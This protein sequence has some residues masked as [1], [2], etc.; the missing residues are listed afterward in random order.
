MYVHTSHACVL[1]WIFLAGTHVG[2]TI[3]C[4]LM[5]KKIIIIIRPHF[6]FR[7]QWNFGNNLNL[8]CSRCMKYCLGWLC[9]IWGICN[10][11]LVQQNWNILLRNIND[12]ILPY[13]LQFCEYIGNGCADTSFGL[14]CHCFAREDVSSSLLQETLYDTTGECT[15]CCR[16]M[17]SHFLIPC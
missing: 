10:V 17:C 6:L 3:C 12:H 2:Y 11:W 9:Q 1:S 14:G 5:Q 13:Y 15:F 7:S 8:F 4:Y 16:K